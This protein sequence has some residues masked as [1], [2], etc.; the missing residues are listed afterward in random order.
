MILI[1][2]KSSL[3]CLLSKQK[4]RPFIFLAKSEESTGLQRR[5]VYSKSNTSGRRLCVSPMACFPYST[6]ISS[7]TLTAETS[8]FN[9]PAQ[10]T[11]SFSRI[12][13]YFSNLFSS[14]PVRFFSWV[15]SL[16]QLLSE[17]IFPAS[18]FLTCCCFKH[19][20]LFPSACFLCPSLEFYPSSK[21]SLCHKE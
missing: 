3:E 8:P 6:E 10:F 13:F 15:C 14:L 9:F 5:K 17:L 1:S 12:Q 20:K 21:S 11:V 4:L 2:S 18:N 16:A 7:L 19:M